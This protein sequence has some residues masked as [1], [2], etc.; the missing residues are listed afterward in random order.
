[1]LCSFAFLTQI[2]KFHFHQ[3]QIS[4]NCLIYTLLTALEIGY[5][6]LI[7][8][9]ITNPIFWINN[10]LRWFQMEK[11]KLLTYHE[12]GLEYFTLVV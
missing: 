9:S 12:V 7:G 10:L 1:V 8:I 2:Y 11:R 3:L 5:L 6:L 4:T